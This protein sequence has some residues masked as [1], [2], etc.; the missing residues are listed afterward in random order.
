MI[1]IITNENKRKFEKQLLHMFEERKVV[2]VDLLKWGL[3]IT[4]GRFEIDQ[5]DDE[6]AVYLLSSHEDGSHLGSLRLL[7][8]DRRSKR[9]V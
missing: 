3:A 7:R 6:N 8:T 5:F 1:Q 9:H 4:D 2:F